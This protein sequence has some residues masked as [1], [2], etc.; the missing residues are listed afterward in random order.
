MAFLRTQTL[1]L[2]LIKV[3][4]KAFASP[5]IIYIFSYADLPNNLQREIPIVGPLIIY[6]YALAHH[7]HNVVFFR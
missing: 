5:S 1:L 3:G 6:A 7:D 4:K 2:I